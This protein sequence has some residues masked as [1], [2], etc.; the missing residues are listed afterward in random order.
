[1]DAIDGAAAACNAA[2]GYEL[3]Q[4]EGVVGWAVTAVSV[5]RADQL[6]LP[7]D[8]T[9]LEQEETVAPGYAVGYRVTMLQFDNAVVAVTAQLHTTSTFTFDQVDDLAEIVGER[10]AKLR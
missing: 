9:A 6:A 5:G 2:G 8:V 7:E 1:M 4:A 3:Y 10:L